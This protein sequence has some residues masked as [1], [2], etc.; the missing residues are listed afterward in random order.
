L[1]ILTSTLIP[2]ASIDFIILGLA[3]FF[4]L[5]YSPKSIINLTYIYLINCTSL[6]YHPLSILIHLFFINL[7]L[8]VIYYISIIC[9]SIS[10]LSSLYIH[11]SIYQLS[12][13]NYLPTYHLSLSIDIFKGAHIFQVAPSVLHTCNETSFA[14]EHSSSNTVCRLTS[15]QWP[16]K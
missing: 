15:R 7:Y 10:Y 3:I 12:V 11:L 5:R 13:S 9:V 8:S 4:W 16:G 14:K 2:Y 6:T 1:P